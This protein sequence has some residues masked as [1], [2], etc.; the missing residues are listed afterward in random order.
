MTTTD[1]LR[2]ARRPRAVTV[3]IVL[4]AIW[5]VVGVLATVLV[6]TSD[7]LTGIGGVLVVVLS[8]VVWAVVAAAVVLLLRG[9]AVARIVLVAV[10]ALRAVLSITEG[11]V[12]LV[13]IAISV[14]AAVLLFVPSARPF[15]RRVDPTE[16]SRASRPDQD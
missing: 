10:A 6:S 1:D 11:G 15:F 16:P 14:A 7:G 2:R 12:S 4:W 8:F 13:L 9:S 5:L 3:A